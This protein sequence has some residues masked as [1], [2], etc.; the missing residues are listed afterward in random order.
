[1]PLFIS[2]EGVEGSGKT[3]QIEMLGSFL[4]KKDRAFIVTREPGGTEV[5]NKIREL[6][7]QN[8][9]DISAYT[10]LFLYLASRVENTEEVIIPS[11]EANIIVITDR[12]ADSTVAYQ[13]FGRGLPE[14][15][16]NELNM[17]ATRGINPN[18]TFLLDFEPECG[19]ERK[20]LKKDRIEKENIDFHVRVR[21]GYRTLARKH[22]DRI[23]VIDAKLP[24]DEI[25]LMI[26]GKIQQHLQ[27][28]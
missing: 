24:A 15:L 12:Y 8:K 21:G 17:I 28:I 6:L 11:L 26:T 23:V 13:V 27:S 20:G 22:P 19:L 3:T 16:V 1:M 5:G 25:H 10:E 7:L 14:T 9:F 18:I 2:F 4:S